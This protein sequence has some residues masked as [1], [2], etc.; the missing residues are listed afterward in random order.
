MKRRTFIKTSAVA[1]AGVT[2]APMILTSCS[3]VKG[4]NDRIL[5]GHIGLGGRG[6]DELKHY[7]L[8]WDEDIRSVAF[9]DVIESRRENAA[10]LA[11]AAYEE[12]GIFGDYEVYN[13]FERLLERR[14]IDAVAINTPDHWHVPLAI[15]A[16]RAGKH[17]HLAKPLGLSHPDFVTLTE[18]V[19]RNKVKFN[20]GTQQRSF[21]FMQQARDLILNGDIGR[22]ERVDV[23]CPRINPV[24]VP[25]CSV[26]SVPAG[27][28]WDRYLGPAPWNDYC[29]ARTLTNSSYFINDFSIG[30]IAGWGAHPLDIMVF[31]I[32]DQMTGLYRAEG[33]GGFWPEG[34]LWDTINS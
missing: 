25:V 27:L 9:C 30:F 11:K 34:G 32:R 33:T 16:A 8:R 19:R 15:M 13:E 2:A 20:Y 4:A 6:T 18:E 23:W 29:P 10:A 7:H 12:K 5:F 1:A 31:C 17:I 28:D 14:D 26:E 24:E 21:P 22:V 3:N